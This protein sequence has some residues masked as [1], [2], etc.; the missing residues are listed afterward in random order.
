M[1]EGEAEPTYSRY[2]GDSWKKT[3]ET[4]SMKEIAKENGWSLGDTIKN[5]SNERKQFI[6]EDV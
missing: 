1:E 3:F 4:K 5:S 6:F 2:Y